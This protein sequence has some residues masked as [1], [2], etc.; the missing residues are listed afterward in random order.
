MR[1]KLPVFLG[2]GRDYIGPQ[3][4]AGQRVLPT[5]LDWSGRAEGRGRSLI[6]SC[7]SH[8]GRG[9]APQKGHSLAPQ[10]TAG[11]VTR[12]GGSRL[13]RYDLT[14]RSSYSSPLRVVRT[15]SRRS[16]RTP[17]Q[18]SRPL[19]SRL[20]TSPWA[21]TQRVP[22]GREPGGWSRRALGRWDCGGLV[23]FDLRSTVSARE[24]RLPRG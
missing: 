8:V 4:G 16:H 13:D 3:E 2:W 18:P 19:P 7:A 12:S 22:S 20:Q 21:G 15:P 10:C 23:P 14:S 1:E 11:R 5:E 17:C 9:A 24:R 6:L